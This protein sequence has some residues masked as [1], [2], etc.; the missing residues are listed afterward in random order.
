MINFTAIGTLFAILLISG[1]VLGIIISSIQ[2]GKQDFW[3]SFKEGFWWSL[4]PT[5]TYL[6]LQ[7]SDYVLSI[8]SQGTKTLFGWTGMVSDDEGYKTLGLCYALILVGLVVTTRM[9]HI[10][11]VSV[12]KPD[13]DELSKWSYEFIHN[14]K[15]KQE[16]HEHDAEINKPDN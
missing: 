6:L 1:F 16:E 5:L 14:Q 4:W 11:D 12:C 15:A 10:L 13:I 9:I 8:F 7:Y 2:C 3:V